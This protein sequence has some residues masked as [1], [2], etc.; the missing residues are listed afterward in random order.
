MVDYLPSVL[1]GGRFVIPLAL[2]AGPR[3]AAAPESF[4]GFTAYTAPKVT[5]LFQ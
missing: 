2:K 3:Y 4:Q 5:Q 1:G